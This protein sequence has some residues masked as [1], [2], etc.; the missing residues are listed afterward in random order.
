MPL[1]YSSTTARR[2]HYYTGASGSDANS[3]RSCRPSPLATCPLRGLL[4][5]APPPESSCAPAQPGAQGGLKPLDVGGVDH[6]ASI[7]L[8]RAQSSP[9]R[10]FR[11]A[12]YAPKT[13][14]LTR[15]RV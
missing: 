5:Y 14:P 3:R 13:T 1:S 8:R 11:T 10:H 7:T 4:A 6:R 9:H 12:H 2:R 15:R